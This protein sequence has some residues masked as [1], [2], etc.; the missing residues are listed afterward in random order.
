MTLFFYVCA[1]LSILLTSIAQIL[2]KIG[3]NKKSTN[4]SIYLNRA[5]MSGYGLFLVVTILSVLALKGIELKTFYAAV[6]A[7]NFILVAIFS[8]KFLG[9]SLS[10]KKVVGILLI[11]LGIIVFNL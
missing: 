3:A 8:W 2:L 5:T 10:K 1:G 7:L 4:E 6:Y 9:E 11:A